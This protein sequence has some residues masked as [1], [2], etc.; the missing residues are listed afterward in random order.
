MSRRLVAALACALLAAPLARAERVLVD[1]VVAVVEAQSITLS[2]VEAETRIRLAVER[3]PAVAMVALDRPLLAAS[4]RRLLEERVVLAEVERLKLFDLEH[5]ERELLLSRLR[6][7]FTGIA[8]WEEF[9]RKLELTE[10]EVGAVLARGLRV[11]RYLDN[12]LKLA[13]QVRDGE[14]D[15]AARA[16]G[17]AAPRTAAARE[18][19]RGKLQRDKLDKLLG[20]LLAELRKR[21]NVRVIDP[22]DAPAPGPSR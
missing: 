22:L 18:A 8:G 13:A 14:L 6:A 19:L 9:L 16:L 3:G 4:L 12:R 15:E 10:E 20:D 2:E 5:S 1:Q 11:S 7:K 21:S 17:E